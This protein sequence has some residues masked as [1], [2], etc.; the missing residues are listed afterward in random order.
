MIDSKQKMHL[1]IGFAMT[2][3]YGAKAAVQDQAPA[4]GSGML[5]RLRWLFPMGRRVCHAL[6]NLGCRISSLRQLR[7]LSDR[8]LRDIGL[9]RHQIGE[10][11]DTLMTA[12]QPETWRRYHPWR[13]R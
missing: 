12:P 6:M 3:T 11:V 5:Q 2:G 4:S 1:K 9:E 7:R 10:V 13:S 8:A